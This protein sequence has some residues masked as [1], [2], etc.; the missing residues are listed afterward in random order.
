MCV[1]DK[2]IN[3]EGGRQMHTYTYIS[4]IDEVEEYVYSPLALDTH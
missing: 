1:E 3:R 4:H 2:L